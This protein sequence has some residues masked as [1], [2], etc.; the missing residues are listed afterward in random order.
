MGWYY[1][2]TPA[3]QNRKLSHHSRSFYQNLSQIF[4]NLIHL[5]LQE[6]KGIKFVKNFDKLAGGSAFA[7]LNAVHTLL[8]TDKLFLHQDKTFL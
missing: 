6:V 1:E 7:V 4:A 2:Q 3:H 5:T 8:Y